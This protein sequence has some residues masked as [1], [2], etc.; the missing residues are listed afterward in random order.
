MT[1]A[2]CASLATL[3]SLVFA[4]ACSKDEPAAGKRA[5]PAPSTVVAASAGQKR[6]EFGPDGK[7]TF[8]IDAPLEKIKGRSTKARGT[9]IVDPQDLKATRGTV[10]VDLDALKTETFDDAAKNKSQ[11][12]HAHNWLEVGEGVDPKQR[13]QNRYA[14]FTVKAIEQLS[15]GKLAEIEV[16]NGERTVT[17]RA[18]GDLWLHGVTSPK[19]AVL[20]VAFAGPAEAPTSL[21]LVS[22][23]PLSV[24]LQEHDVKPRDLAGKFLSGALQQIGQKI[25]DRVQISLDLTAK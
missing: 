18:A 13:E 24:S 15:A 25:D 8:L 12:E 23:E 4:A 11:T 22:N 10:E 6:F 1:L 7:T 16:K 2:H 20:T 3:A 14:R 5:P 19:T 17:V 9:L 21:H